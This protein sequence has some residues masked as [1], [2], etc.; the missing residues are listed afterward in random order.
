[1]SEA[2]GKRSGRDTGE[3]QRSDDGTGSR[4][5][6]IHQVKDHHVD[7][8]KASVVRSESASAGEAGLASVVSHGGVADLPDVQRPLHCRGNIQDSR[9]DGHSEAILPGL[10]PPDKDCL[11]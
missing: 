4:L 8:R 6:F 11:L 9:R 7:S 10:S 2:G 5:A 3:I 1:M